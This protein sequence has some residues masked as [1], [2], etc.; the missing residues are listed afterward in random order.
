MG[1]WTEIAFATIA[2]GG[3][4][5]E[6]LT[7]WNSSHKNY[8]KELYQLS[9]F[10]YK[11]EKSLSMFP[12]L[13][14]IKSN[15]DLNETDSNILQK[16]YEVKDYLTSNWLITTLLTDVSNNE[17]HRVA[18]LGA[19]QNQLDMTYVHCQRGKVKCNKKYNRP[20]LAVS[21]S[22][23]HT[24]DPCEGNNFTE[25]RIQ[26]INNGI[27]FVFMTGSQLVASMFDENRT[28][29]IPGFQ[30]TYE[31]S[32]GSDGIRLVIHAPDVSFWPEHE[33]IDISPGF[34][35]TICVTSKESIRLNAPYSSCTDHNMEVDMLIESI[36]SRL[37]YTPVRNEG[38]HE[39][40]YTTLE[41]RSSCLQRHIWESCGC[42]LM[43][44]FL[45]F[46]NSS[47]MCGYLG[48]ETKM[49]YNPTKYGKEHC[50]QIENMTNPKCVAFLSKI[51][52]DLKCVR[53]VL[54]RNI[55]MNDDDEDDIDQFE[56]N[57]PTPCYSKEYQVSIGT[58]RWPRRG[59][60]LDSA[61]R[62]IVNR[63]VIPIFERKGK[64]LLDGA[65]GYLSQESNKRDIME[66]F[67]RVTVYFKSLKVERIEQVAA[68][69]L[70][71]LFSDIGKTC[72]L[73]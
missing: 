41:C 4:E 71:D 11:L 23:C 56:C 38:V 9:L 17:S 51:F 52:S 29:D 10:L 39:S 48:N 18:R 37:G 13:N 21:H 67:A 61:Y 34:S 14:E 62:G 70:L 63:T 22:G 27:T 65:I 57:C 15:L 59:P 31:P 44:E 30:N 16:W 45:P 43:G 33:G 12:N 25:S 8:T 49:L 24:Y 6:T 5:S 72:F 58:S 28:W 20:F 3:M 1:L 60:E 36:T 47:L 66:N 2:T 19:L 26:G 7:K 50:L 64:F 54:E 69:T 53:N 73:R 46:F 32:A 35:S 40:A 55:H 42:L 68:F